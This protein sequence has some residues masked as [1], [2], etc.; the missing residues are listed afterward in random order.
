MVWDLHNNSHQLMNEYQKNRISI[1][2]GRNLSN[3]KKQ[4]TRKLQR[5][6][7]PFVA[8]GI[9]KNILLINWKSQCRLTPILE[10]T[11]DQMLRD[12][13][14][15][16]FFR[17]MPEMSIVFLIQLQSQAIE[18]QIHSAGCIDQ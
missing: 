13:F 11:K 16:A 6:V 15:W 10:Y 8:I 7:G 17:D 9:R 1:L 5:L 14:L 18:F 4:L 3:A 12:L 2:I